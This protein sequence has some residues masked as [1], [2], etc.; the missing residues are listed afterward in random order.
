[1]K[2]KT[3]IKKIYIYV[4]KRWVPLRWRTNV[5]LCAANVCVRWPGLSCRYRSTVRTL[6]RRNGL[7][8]HSMTV[9]TNGFFFYFDFFFNVGGKMTTSYIF[10]MLATRM[11][12][13][14]TLVL[15]IRKRERESLMHLKYKN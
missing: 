5:I 8:E 13:I 4:K 3:K 6:I 2:Y 15:L 12:Y 14:Y 7:S 1:M 9:P 10:K 11:L